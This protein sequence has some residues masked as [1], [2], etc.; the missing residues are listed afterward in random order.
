METT[1]TVYKLSHIIPTDMCEERL[2]PIGTFNNIKDAYPTLINLARYQAKLDLNPW[3][4]V[5]VETDDLNMKD[6][7]IIR[8]PNLQVEVTLRRYTSSTG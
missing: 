1:K 2:E 4:V 5:Y 8:W 7:Q 3:V 6:Y